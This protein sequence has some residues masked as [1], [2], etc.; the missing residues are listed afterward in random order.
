MAPPPIN[1]MAETSPRCPYCRRDDCYVPVTDDWPA[2]AREAYERGGYEH[3]PTCA[4]GQAKDMARLVF[5]DLRSYRRTIARLEAKR[6]RANDEDE[7]FRLGADIESMVTELAK[8]ERLALA[9]REEEL[10]T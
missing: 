8:L 5:G 9:I 4:L 7:R 1:A 2:W 3:A 6:R 10:A